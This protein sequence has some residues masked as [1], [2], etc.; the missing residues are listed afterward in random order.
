MWLWKNI[1][2]SVKWQPVGHMEEDEGRAE[3]SG[4]G[5]EGVE[6]GVWLKC[7]RCG[8]ERGRRTME[9]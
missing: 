7:M 9:A 8:V 3:G 1:V 4:G 5:L 2:L 6:D